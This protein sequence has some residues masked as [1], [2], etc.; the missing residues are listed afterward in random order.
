MHLL[1][2]PGLALG[3]PVRLGHAWLC[4]LRAQHILHLVGFPQP[5]SAGC[6]G[7]VQT[8]VCVRGAVIP[9]GLLCV[10]N[11]VF[12]CGLLCVCSL[13]PVRAPLCVCSAWSRAGSSVCVQCL[14][15]CGLLCVCAL[16]WSRE[17]TV[18]VV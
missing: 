15:L 12:L 6:S 1:W 7:P 3:L 17:P 13:G 5:R 11:A 16:Q 2:P 10:C 4:G 9:C 14:V 18:C 8:P